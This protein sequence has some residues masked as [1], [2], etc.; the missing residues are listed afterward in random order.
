MAASRRL[1]AG[2]KPYSFDD[3]KKGA[4][5]LMRHFCTR[6]KPLD[7]EQKRPLA[8]RNPGWSRLTQPPAGPQFGRISRGMWQNAYVRPSP[9]G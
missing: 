6:T 9:A 7:D 5:I 1:S 8:S 4:G 2:F 3:R